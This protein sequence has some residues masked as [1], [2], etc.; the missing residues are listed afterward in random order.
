MF[1]GEGCPTFLTLLVPYT[2][3]DRPLVP[4]KTALVIESHITLVTQIVLDLLVDLTNVDFQVNLSGGLIGALVAFEVLQPFMYEV[5][6][7]FQGF[8]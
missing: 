1:C 2:K 4:P 5:D 7:F 3:M 8:I 6:V